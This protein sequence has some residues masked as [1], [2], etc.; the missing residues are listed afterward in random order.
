M[1]TKRISK[2]NRTGI[3]DAITSR[4][5]VVALIILVAEGLFAIAIYAI[6]VSQKLDA[7]YACIS[8]LGV[9]LLG[10][11]WLERSAIVTTNPSTLPRTEAET[12]KRLYCGPTLEGEWLSFEGIPDAPASYLDGKAS[13]E[14]KC[15][16]ISMRLNMTVSRTGEPT[17]RSFVYQGEF[18]NGQLVLL[19]DD[20]QASGYIVGAVVLRLSSDLKRLIGKSTYFHDIKNAVV[21][22]DFWL[23]RP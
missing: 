18:R 3:L 7:F 10:C 6:P 13:I 1:S 9:A 14:Q 2:V 5:K 22:Y 16:E 20:E 19:F 12:D 4:T 23:Q 8:V 11:I 21:S 17:N 15:H